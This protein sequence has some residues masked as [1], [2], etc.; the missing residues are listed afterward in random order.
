LQC[1]TT[2][3]TQ[4]GEVTDL[5]QFIHN[6]RNFMHIITMHSTIQHPSH[7]PVSVPAGYVSGY[8]AI[9]GSRRI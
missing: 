2:T 3:T 9:F 1:A 8:P 4:I 7:Y 6:L 5:P